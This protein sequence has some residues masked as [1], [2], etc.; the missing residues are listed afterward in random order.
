MERGPTGIWERQ[1]GFDAVGPYDAFVPTPLPPVPALTWNDARHQLLAEANLAIGRLDAM[2]SL[3]PDPSLF[4]YSYIR[5]EA[6]LSSQIEGTQSSL[7]DLLAFENDAAPG[8]PLNDVQEV[9]NYVAA[10]NEGIRLLRAGTP[11][12]MRLLTQVHSVLLGKG[13]GASARP[14]VVRTS[15]NWIGGATPV[16]AIFVP[17]PVAQVETCLAD[18]ERFLNDIPT[19]SPTLVKAALAHVQFETIHPFLDGN[20]RLG[21]LL[22]SMLLVHE[23]TLTEPLLYLSL[24]FKQHRQTYYDLLQRVRFQGD[25]ESWLDFFLSGVRDTAT[26]ATRTATTAIGIFAADRQRIEGLG[27]PASSA[28]RVHQHLQRHPIATTIKIAEA[29]GLSEPTVARS[30]DH[31][32]ELSIAR[33]L[34]GKQR[35]RQYAYRAFLDLLTSGA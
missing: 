26:G 24:Y 16:Q 21:R 6:V 31:L 22:I 9:S 2:S 4:L 3:L 25:W 1:P 11:L 34:T 12:S 35:H 32:I 29:T 19:R 18:L 8:V 28:L 33:E 30:L 13:R 20:G 23:K 15:P 27:R 17:P 10:M 14:G 5:K 7:S